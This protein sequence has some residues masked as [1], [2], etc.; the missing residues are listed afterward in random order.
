MTTPDI[1]LSELRGLIHTEQ[2]HDVRWAALTAMLEMWPPELIAEYALPYLDG[3]LRD[4]TSARL[5][6]SHWICGDEYDVEV[7]P[8][9]PL[10]RT[11]A[12]EHHKEGA[13]P[14]MSSAYM[15]HL[16]KLDLAL[17][18]L[19]AEGAHALARAQH[20]TQLTELD[21][22]FNELGHQGAQA[23]ANAQHLT[24]LRWLDLGFNDLGDQG[25]SAIA[26][27]PHV[28]K[29]RWLNVRDNEIGDE[30]AL[31]IAN[32]PSL[33]ELNWLDLSYNRIGD[34]GVFALASSAQLTKL[35][36]LDLSHNRFSQEGVREFTNCVSCHRSGEDEGGERGE[37][38][39][40]DNDEH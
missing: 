28:V 10:V 34:E 18:Q 37:G 1:L 12:H 14:I 17:N 40:R 3:V 33:K 6:P 19:G 39:E 8:A 30:G 7:H 20:L 25:A 31:A 29:L 5:A 22:Y 16:N 32:S 13:L 35:T 21:L 38:R 2:D 26:N 9:W 24:R 27:S 15:A 36:S 11:Y 23:L 4:D